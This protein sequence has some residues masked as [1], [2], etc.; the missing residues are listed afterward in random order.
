MSATTKYSPRYHGTWSERRRHGRM[1]RIIAAVFATAAGAA[2]L[3]WSAAV[4]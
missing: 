4:R 2:F 3:L 1:A